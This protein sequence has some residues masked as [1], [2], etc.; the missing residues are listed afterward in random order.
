MDTC[1]SGPRKT[2]TEPSSKYQR[3]LWIA[4]VVNAAMFAVELGA[5]HQADSASLLADAVDFFGDAANYAVT[6]FAL[7]LGVVWRAR[8]ALLK[9]VTMGLYGIFI[10][11]RVGW[12]ALEGAV[13]HASTMSVVGLVALTANVAVA[14][15]LFAYRDGDANMRSVWLCS[16]NDA[17][18]NLA[19]IGAGIMVS[20][21]H[22]RWPDLAVALT[23]AALALTSSWTVIRQ[24]AEELAG[25]GAPQKTADGHGALRSRTS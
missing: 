16:R 10:L 24:A 22:S 3:A 19:V 25:S 23:M 4:L 6:L 17:I 8:A 9:A 12:N 7:S 18:G 15:L 20:V 21:M 2:P 1:C 11:G 14:A 5:G 13:P